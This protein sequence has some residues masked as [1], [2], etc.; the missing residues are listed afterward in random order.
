[1]SIRTYE[2]QVFSPLFSWVSIVTYAQA[3]SIR[4]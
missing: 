2:E 1:M 3:L 4:L